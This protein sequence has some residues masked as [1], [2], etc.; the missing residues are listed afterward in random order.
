MA[1]TYTSKLN[2]AKPAHGDVNWHIPVNENWDKLDSKLGPLYEDI[3]SDS[4]K[5]TLNKNV[6]ANKKNIDNVE[7]LTVNKIKSTKYE[8]IADLSLSKLRYSDNRLSSVGSMGEWNTV[9]TTPPAGANVNGVATIRYNVYTSTNYSCAVRLLKNDVAIPGSEVSVKSGGTFV[10]NV[11]V[12]PNDII[13]LQISAGNYTTSNNI[14][15][16][17]ALMIPI[18]DENETWS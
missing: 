15:E 14:F 11:P 12:K 13:K 1:N 18:I 4:A 7:T 6:D 2:L 3:S 16:I 9:K 10:I 8:W 5:L 17:Y